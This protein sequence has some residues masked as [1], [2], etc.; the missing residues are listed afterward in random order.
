M[1]QL[2]DRLTADADL[3]TTVDRS[4]AALG[5]PPNAFGADEAGVPGR[6]GR[7]LR[8]HWMAVLDARRRE[9]TDTAA[10]LTDLA[11][12]LRATTHSYAD[13]DDEAARRVAR[14]S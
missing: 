9:A 5:V 7:E 1:D 14:R 10:R 2:A 11:Q 12:A 4:V 6:L 13:T 8:A 3:V